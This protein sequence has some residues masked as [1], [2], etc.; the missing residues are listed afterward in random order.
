MCGIAGLFD[1]RGQ[2]NFDPELIRRAT[3]ALAHRGPDGDGFFAAPGIALGHR[4]LAI[5]D[6][7]SG[8]QPMHAKDGSITITFNGEI[9]NYKE[10]RAELGSK[11]HGFA[12]ASDTE[13]IIASANPPASTKRSA[14]FAARI[15]A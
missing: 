14:G 12:T 8:S 4:K 5:I 1:T 10:L 3:T 15:A 9:F 2:R 11:G 6:L 7:A 13:A